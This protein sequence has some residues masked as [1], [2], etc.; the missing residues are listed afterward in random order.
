MYPS[1]YCTRFLNIPGG[2][3]EFLPSTLSPHCPQAQL[4]GDTVNQPPK[5]IIP[6]NDGEEGVEVKAKSGKPRICRL[7]EIK[8]A[9][10]FL[11]EYRE[12]SGQTLPPK[13]SDEKKTGGPSE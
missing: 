6:T 3:L 7:L 9:L 2:C 10:G 4:H 1:I 8:D 5:F 13:F 11:M 12:G